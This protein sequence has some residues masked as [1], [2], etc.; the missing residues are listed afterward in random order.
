MDIFAKKLKERAAQLGI[1]NA[2][3][4]RLCGLD[5][6]RY[7]NYI[8]NA[9]EPDLATLAKI[10]RTLKVSTDHLMGL[11]VAPPTD[12]RG[13]LLDRLSVSGSSLSDDQLRM[14]VTQVEALTIRRP[15]RAE[16]T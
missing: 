15:R 6:R 1:S 11:T 8:N 16:K 12:E 9:R 4:A 3:A 2:Q 7:A 5:E 13:Q 14:F 10:A